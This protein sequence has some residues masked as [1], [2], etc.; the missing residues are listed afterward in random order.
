MQSY[1]RNVMGAV[2]VYDI[3]NRTS[4][5][6]L[7]G[8]ISK[9]QENSSNAVILLVGNKS[10]MIYL[11]A[12]Q[13][14]EGISVAKKFHMAFMETSALEST[15]VD[16]AFKTI[17]KEIIHVHKLG[18]KISSSE[19]PTVTETISAPISITQ[20]QPEPVHQAGKQKCAC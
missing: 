7:P 20:T 16:E 17:I 2:I 6:E 9:I 4:F 5:D 12:V 3:T 1:Y 10:D 8:W 13:T 18:T 14:D 11:R 19:T 15:N